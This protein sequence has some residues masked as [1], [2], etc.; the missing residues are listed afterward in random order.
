MTTAIPQSPEESTETITGL[1][2]LLYS[3]CPPRTSPEIIVIVMHGF[4]SNSR[5]MM[6]L[7]K[8]VLNHVYRSAAPTLF[9]CPMAPILMGPQSGCWF[10][11]EVAKIFAGVMSG[12]IAN[13]SL[14]GMDLASKYV[15]LIPLIIC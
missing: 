7:S 14:G 3:S 13:A 11:L 4:G 15:L 5:D 2:C 12:T 10:E 8:Q 1:D 6:G 9:V